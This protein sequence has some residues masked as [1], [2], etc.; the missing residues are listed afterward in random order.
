MVNQKDYC[1]SSS[2][3]ASTPFTFNLT[4][5]NQKFEARMPSRLAFANG[6]RFN[7]T[8]EDSFCSVEVK[9][10][11]ASIVKNLKKN[12]TDQSCS[13]DLE[14]EEAIVNKNLTLNYRIPE[15]RFFDSDNNEVKPANFTQTISVD[16]VVVEADDSSGKGLGVFSTIL[17]YIGVVLGLLCVLLKRDNYQKW[18][19][20][21]LIT[22]THLIIFFFWIRDDFAPV[23]NTFQ[24]HLYNNLIRQIN[25]S[26]NSTMISEYEESPS[27]FSDLRVP[28]YKK[29]FN[30]WI[31]SH[32]FYN[33]LFIMFL[34]LL[35]CAIYLFFKLLACSQKMAK[36]K[37]VTTVLNFFEFDGLYY[38]LA[39]FFVESCV[40]SFFNFVAP[41]GD[42]N[43]FRGS[44]IFAVIYLL[45]HLALLIFLA[46]IPSNNYA[47]LD[48]LSFKRRFGFCYSNYQFKKGRK[49]REFV[50][51]VKLFLTGLILA[52]VH[53]A[54]AQATFVFILFLICLVLV[55][56]LDY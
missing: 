20:L 1:V 33:F 53:N 12:L 5:T 38:C 41:R 48:D 36:S 51:F 28:T 14:P 34:Q 50:Y 49:Y 2:G 23:L 16:P 37:L 30:N 11:D 27:F 55:F 10:H 56:V 7:F 26:F 21:H 25:G 18:L 29:F 44:I 32:F 4:Q 35:F 17:F 15:A 47:T 43:S 40:F 24:M 39:F 9:E 46:A 52:S 8:D 42:N 6:T 19:L 22:S 45:I 54:K 3:S 31:V 13:F